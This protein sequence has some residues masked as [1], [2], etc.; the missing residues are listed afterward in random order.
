MNLKKLVRS[1]SSNHS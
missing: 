1:C